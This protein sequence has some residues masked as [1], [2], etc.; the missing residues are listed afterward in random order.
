MTEGMYMMENGKT[1][2][3]M[4]RVFISIKRNKPIIMATGKMIL[5]KE[6]V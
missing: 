6:K 1:G 2:R 3:K 4:V 5:K